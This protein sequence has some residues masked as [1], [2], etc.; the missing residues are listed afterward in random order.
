MMMKTLPGRILSRIERMISAPGLRRRQRAYRRLQEARQPVVVHLPEGLEL[1]FHPEGHCPELLYTV[2][3]ER[4]EL[5]LAARFLK[6]GMRVIDIGANVGLYSVLA[7]K[8]IGPAGEVIAFEP[9][10]ESYR[11]LLR[12][13]ELNHCTTVTTNQLALSDKDGQEL[14]LHRDAGFRDGD[15]YLTPRSVYPISRTE[16]DDPG[17]SEIVR[18]TTLDVF[19]Q[20]QLDDQVR[21]DFLKMD[22]EGGEFSAF[23]GAQRFLTFNTDLMM[24]FECSRML[25]AL[26]GH[27]QD[28]VFR[29]LH[30]YGFYVYAWKKGV[31]SMG[32][33]ALET[34]GNVWATRRRSL[35]PNL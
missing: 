16:A 24:L 26:A 11:R 6:P 14:V 7:A 33:E 28:D 2:D 8:R 10:S 5:S 19:L 15:R 23:K 34:A 21:F 17:D 31:W 32:P 29:R 12:N 13:L 20:R 30:Q 22:I 1:A 9:S 18:V 25:C 35:L 3:F 27:T 4:T